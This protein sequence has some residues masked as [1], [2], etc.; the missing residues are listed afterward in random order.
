M[1]IGLLLLGQAGLG[2][3]VWIEIA[4]HDLK[5]EGMFSSE[6][7]RLA[8]ALG[9]HWE[10]YL[11]LRDAVPEDGIIVCN[12]PISKS[13]SGALQEMIL[14][15]SLRHSL[16]PRVVRE[17]D[18]DAAEVRAAFPGALRLYVCDFA[19]DSGPPLD[20]LLTRIERTDLIELWTVPR[21]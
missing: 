3:G 20:E 19:P 6:E 10:T 16:H 7:R 8:R 14:L 2:A 17:M 13:L 12:L 15:Q 1:I 9:A 11:V 18:I 5:T 21:D 4:V